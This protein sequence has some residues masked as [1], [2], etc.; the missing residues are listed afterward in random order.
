G[1]QPAQL[2]ASK[3]VVLTNTWNGRISSLKA[4][5]SN[6]NIENEF[7]QAG[8]I[9]TSYF[10]PKGAPNKDLAM[11]F[12]NFAMSVEVQAEH[13]RI[14]D[15]FPTNMDAI[16]LLEDDV[17]ER[18]GLGEEFGA[19]TYLIDPYYWAEYEDEVI[20]RYKDWQLN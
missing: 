6:A 20:E 8:E 19:D 17:L 3:D 2:L 15:Y 14:I 11:E 4:E 10:V 13:S 7:N 12:I 1:A 18:L 5:D 16:E 9:Y